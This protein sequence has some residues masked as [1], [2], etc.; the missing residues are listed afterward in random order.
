MTYQDITRNYRFYCE[1]SESFTQERITRFR[2]FVPLKG[3][4]HFKVV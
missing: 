4:S 1:D 2:L 3:L